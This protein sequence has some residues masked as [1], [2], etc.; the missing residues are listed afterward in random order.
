[1]VLESNHNWDNEPEDEDADEDEMMMEEEGRMGLPACGR[2]R[3]TD[4]IVGG[5][6]APPES[7]P[8]AASLQLS[9][10][11]HFCG[12]SL[13]HPQVSLPN[14]N[15]LKHNQSLPS[16]ELKNQY[17]AVELSSSVGDH[18]SALRGLGSGGDAV[19]DP[20][21]RAQPAREDGH[22]EGRKDQ[23]PPALQLQDQQQRHCPH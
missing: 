17:N 11:F 19:S 15:E 12:A 1:M 22:Q 2:G 4:R 20:G 23:N 5:Q 8:W 16:L 9:Y 13:I 10:G 18:C 7:F 3:S 21:W 6:I 14:W